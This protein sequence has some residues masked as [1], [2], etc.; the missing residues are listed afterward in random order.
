MRR[1]RESFGAKLLSAFVV[2][3]GVPLVATFFVA[4]AVTEGQIEEATARTVQNAGRLFEERS[5]VQRQLVATLARPFTEGS[6]A[7]A[8]LRAAIEE[9]EVEVLA[10]E[11]AYEMQLQNIPEALLVFTDAD[12]APVLSLIRDRQFVDEDPANIRPLADELL[13]GDALE[14]Q[15]YRVVDGTMY[16]VRTVYLELGYRPIGTIAVG[17]PVSTDDLEAV[18]E[19]GAFEACFAWNGRCVVESAGVD[20]ELRQAMV[21]TL[22][23]DGPR[24]VQSAAG[25]WSIRAEPL[26]DGRPDEGQ[27]VVA[28]PLGPVLAPFSSILRALVLS[29]TS[30]LVLAILFG[31]LMSRSFTRPVRALVDAT[32]RVAGGDY[33]TEVSVDSQ[34]E[35]GTLADAFNEMT[36]GLKMREQYRSVLNKVVSQGIAEELMR[37]SVELGGEN[38]DISVLF[39]DIRGFTPL[40]E[41]MEPQQVIGL[42]NECMEHLASAVDA[43]GGVVDKFIGDEVMAVFGA[44]VEQE[45]HALRAARAAL[46]MREGI[47]AMNRDRAA[48]GDE[49]LQLGIGI[50]TG[51]AVAGNM[52]SSDRMNYTVLGAT[53][54]LA[55]RLTSA[56]SAGQILL[57]AETRR[58]IGTSFNV[59][60][61]GGM[62]LKGFSATSEVFN[63]DGAVKSV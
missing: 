39:A 7:L 34:D 15:A 30:A 18:A 41:G 28:V 32:G 27:R 11:V 62:G 56:A 19:V 45:D 46:R 10:G 50:A 9:N 25:A 23:A 14:L 35:L 17:L 60:S 51:V 3:I 2:T 1:I 8:R 38:R 31:T 13:T 5:E 44:P 21:A 24:R 37:G 52:G 53:V 59:T 48:R 43:E 4:R 16:N 40:T 49:E 12:G 57:S 47:Q 58:V 33:Q 36:R 55:A 6:R 26:I 54:N 29:V 61:L 42:L 20:V 22:G 63:L